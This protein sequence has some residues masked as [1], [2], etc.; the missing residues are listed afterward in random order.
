M[1]FV[2]I[3]V[4]TNVSAASQEKNY[5]ILKNEDEILDNKKEK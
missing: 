1:L 4:A 3:L 5:N 2:A